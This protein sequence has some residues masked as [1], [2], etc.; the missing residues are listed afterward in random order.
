MKRFGLLALLLVLPCLG[1]TLRGYGFP[2]LSPENT[3]RR[4]DDGARAAGVVLAREAMQA[5]TGLEVK[6]D[7]NGKIVGMGSSGS[8][9][10]DA[11]KQKLKTAGILVEASCELPIDLSKFKKV[12]VSFTYPDSLNLES[13]DEVKA[14]MA[15]YRGKLGEALAGAIPASGAGAYTISGLINDVALGE[16]EIKGTLYIGEVVKKP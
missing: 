3:K 8:V 15:F 4:P 6:I 1:I 2:N 7:E 9:N 13:F 5:L 12:A 10:L 14:Y 11:S 16:K